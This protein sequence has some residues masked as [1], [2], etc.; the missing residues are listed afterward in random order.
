MRNRFAWEGP[1]QA[2]I[3]AQ[4]AECKVNYLGKY[5]ANSWSCLAGNA[6]GIWLMVVKPREA[7]VSSGSSRHSFGL[8][9]EFVS[10]QVDS[11]LRPRPT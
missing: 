8:S 2:K 6:S 11:N 10:L 5:W 7:I 3:R 1:K 4:Q 9:E